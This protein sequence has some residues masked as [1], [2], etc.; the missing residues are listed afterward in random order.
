VSSFGL[1]WR[2]FRVV[3]EKETAEKLYLKLNPA[4]HKVMKH[5]RMIL[6]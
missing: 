3:Y 4:M 6:G 5:L 1:D 2:Y